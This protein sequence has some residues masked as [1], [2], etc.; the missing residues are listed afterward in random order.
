M[1]SVIYTPTVTIFDEKQRLNYKANEEVIKYLI[2]SGVNGLVP[3]GS[4]GEFTA[5]SLEDKKELVNLYLKNSS[6]PIL[7]GTSSL[8]FSEVVELSNYSI[9][10]GALGVLVVFPFYFGANQNNIFEF[11]DKLANSVDGDI[12]IYNYP[13]R[14]GSDI[15]VQTILNLI[16]KNKNIKGIK[17]TTAQIP[18]TKD[19][20][21][22][23]KN[24]DF[25]VFSGFDDHFIDNVLAGGAG[26]ICGLSN[27]VPKIWSN[28]VKAT[29]DENFKD[30]SKYSK[31]INKLMELYSLDAN[32]SL[33]FKKL[34]N[35]NGLNLNEVA[36]FPFNSLEES[37]F[38]KAKEILKEALEII[39]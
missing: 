25:K 38:K 10:N 20:I 13:A 39:E 29:N 33:I 26:G 35:L 1:K 17:D 11:Y 21:K 3:F 36:I 30:I 28:F 8:V 24:Y 6:I 19:I 18:H 14:T 27:I 16:D 5:F 23:T 34:M 7:V 15:N 12:Y 32:F 4:T 2:N 31:V 9:K 37:K 22:A